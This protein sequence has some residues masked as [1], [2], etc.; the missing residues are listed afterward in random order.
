MS[1]AR[2][3][4]AAGASALTAPARAPGR[5]PPSA[6]LAIAQRHR[7]PDL[8]ARVLAGRGVAPDDV[9]TFLDPTL[10]SLLPDPSVLTDMDKAAARIADAIG[11]GEPVAIFGDYDVD[12]AASAALLTRFLRHQGL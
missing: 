4:A 1:S 10:K 5:P 6:A 9:T 8:V 7:V 12:G 3:P 11:A 2:S